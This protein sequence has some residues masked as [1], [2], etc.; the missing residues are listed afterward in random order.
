MHHLK[1]A[2]LG[3]VFAAFTFTSSAFAEKMENGHIYH[4]SRKGEMTHLRALRAD[5]AREMIKEAEPVKDP[6]AYIMY[7]GQLYRL[8]NHKMANGKMTF[9]VWGIPFTEPA[10]E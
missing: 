4:M 8:S 9:D 6:A 2:G 10:S 3:L 1:I 5:E 7:D